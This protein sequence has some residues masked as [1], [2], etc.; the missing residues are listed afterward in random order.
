MRPVY[1]AR[2]Q[3]YRL[4]ELLWCHA[5]KSDHL[6]LTVHFLIIYL[7]SAKV[8]MY[9]NY[10]PKATKGRA[11]PYIT[12]TLFFWAWISLQDAKNLPANATVELPALL[13]ALAPE[14]GKFIFHSLECCSQRYKWILALPTWFNGLKLYPIVSGSNKILPLVLRIFFLAASLS[15]LLL[16]RTIHFLWHRPWLTVDRDPKL[17]ENFT[18]HSPIFNFYLLNTYLYYQWADFSFGH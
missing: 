18:R 17:P 13:T 4:L 12:D 15:L 9:N 14:S 6:Q 1:F 3:I 11:N 5:T 8:L 2:L 10:M 16:R 7:P